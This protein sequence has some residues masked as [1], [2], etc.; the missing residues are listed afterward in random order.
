MRYRTF[1]PTGRPV[2]V[3]GQGTWNM[4]RDDRGRPS[5]RSGA[6]PRP[7]HDPRRHGRDVRRR[8]GRGARRRGHRRPARRGLPRLQGAAPATPPA[9][10]TLEACE[11]ASARLRHRPA[12]LLPPALA[13][14]ST[15]SR[16]PFAAFEELRG[17]GQD[18][19]LGRE[20]LRRGA[21]WTRRSRIAGDGPHRLQPGAL[22]P[23]GA[24]HRARRAPVLRGARH[25]RRRLQPVR[26]GALP[27]GPSRRRPGARRGRRGPRR[28]PP[29]GGARASSCA[30]PSSSPSRRPRRAEHAADNAAAADSRSTRRSAAST[31]HFPW[32]GGEKASLRC[33]PWYHSPAGTILSSF[34]ASI[35]PSASVSLRALSARLLRMIARYSK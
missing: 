14:R 11:R 9:A 35:L 4:E 18:P 25:R 20:Q 13:R 31:R 7:R 27:R 17:G 6:R 12:R 1:G 32:G 29:P 24:R 19:L 3:I 5:R 26:L 23:R 8:R 33:R 16:T 28:H 15:R 10:G 22:P 21:S 30:G 34:T 2:P